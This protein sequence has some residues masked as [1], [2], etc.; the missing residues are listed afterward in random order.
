MRTIKNKLD[1][2]TSFVVFVVQNTW[3]YILC[4]PAVLPH[5]DESTTYISE[6]EHR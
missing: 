4:T 5:G 2:E 1:K 3:Q 6:W